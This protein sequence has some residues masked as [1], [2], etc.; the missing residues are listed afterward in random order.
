MRVGGFHVCPLARSYSRSPVRPWLGCMKKTLAV[1][2]II[3]LTGCAHFGA[4]VAQIN[5]SLANDPATVSWTT[6]I[7]TPWGVQHSK[8]VRVGN[9]TNSVS[10]APDGTVTV[11]NNSPIVK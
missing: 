9:L 2:G 5:K 8:L 3:T 1:I 11:N 6:D 7:G 4:Q 10:I